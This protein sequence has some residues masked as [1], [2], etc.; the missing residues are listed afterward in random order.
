MNTDTK[1][2]IGDTSTLTPC[3]PF[4]GGSKWATKGSPVRPMRSWDAPTGRGLRGRTTLCTW[5]SAGPWPS[6]PGAAGMQRSSFE[7]PLLHL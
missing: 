7:Q 6:R 2:E 5:H 1:Q 3:L 4:T